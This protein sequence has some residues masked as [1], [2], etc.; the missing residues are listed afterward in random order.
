MEDVYDYIEQCPTIYI[1]EL[2]ILI[3]GLSENDTNH[4][5]IQIYEDLYCKFLQYKNTLIETLKDCIIELQPDFKNTEFN[6]W[7]HIQKYL[8]YEIADN[9]S[10]FVKPKTEMLVI[11]M[12]FPKLYSELSDSYGF[13]G[14]KFKL[15]FSRFKLITDNGKPLEFI[16][17]SDL[18][19][20]QCDTKL[21]TIWREP[22]EKEFIGTLSRTPKKENDNSSMFVLNNSPVPKNPKFL[23]IFRENSINT[24]E[25][26]AVPAV[27]KNPDVF[28]KNKK[29]KNMNK[30]N[31]I[32][33]ESNIDTFPHLGETVK[34]TS[35][36]GISTIRTHNDIFSAIH[37]GNMLP[38]ALTQPTAT[39]PIFEKPNP[40]IFK[41]TETPDNSGLNK[42]QSLP[43]PT[44]LYFNPTSEDE[45]NL[46]NKDKFK[47][48]LKK[49]TGTILLKCIKDSRSKRSQNLITGLETIKTIDLMEQA[50]EIDISLKTY[51][52]SKLLKFKRDYRY[53]KDVA[54]YCIEEYHETR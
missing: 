41:I 19:L 31:L 39:T 35:S 2:P 34:F 33:R 28:Q 53:M 6:D 21:S 8:F 49:F 16:D 25:S 17:K 43:P 4:L 44:L 23:D 52:K 42:V 10:N 32:S 13:I 1:M 5:S 9:L 27:T 11:P 12:S 7:N 22:F 45:L 18:L 48:G 15:K 54:K 14:F 38:S 29:N 26:I 51:I 3:N 46:S 20:T 30:S 36:S 47:N 24:N 50:P 40:P 37:S